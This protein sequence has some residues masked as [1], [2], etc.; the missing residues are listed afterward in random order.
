MDEPTSSLDI[1]I[2]NKIL[3]NLLN[4]KSITCIVITHRI[5]TK[6]FFDRIF[7]FKGTKLIESS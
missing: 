3:D 4:L 1:I 7:Q 6:Y 2:Q 5:E